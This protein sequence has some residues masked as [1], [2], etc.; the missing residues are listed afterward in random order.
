MRKSTAVA[1]TCVQ[2]QKDRCEEFP[3]N[4]NAYISEQDL[5]AGKPHKFPTE[6]IPPPPPH[7]QKGDLD[8]SI[9]FFEGGIY[10]KK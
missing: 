9:I 5:R 10:W 2:M 4:K 7:Q 1:Q 8:T 6:G 3:G